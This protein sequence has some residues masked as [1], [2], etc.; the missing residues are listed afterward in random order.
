[1]SPLALPTLLLFAAPPGPS[2]REESFSLARPAE[3]VA[4]LRAGCEACSWEVKG[5][6][7]AVLVLSV[8]GGYSQHLTLVRGAVPQEYRVLLGTLEAGAHRLSV[9]LD[10]GMTPRAVRSVAVDPVT[11]LPVE[12][13]TPEHRALA[14]APLLHAR[15]NTLG[16]FSDLPLLSWYE[17]E[18]TPRGTRL[19][20]SVVFSN[21][22]GGT[23]PDRLLATW[24]RL[25]DI[26]YVYGVELDAAGQVLEETYQGRDHKILAFRGKRLGRH[27]LLWV[28]T[29]NNM[30]S[31]EGRTSLR[32]APAPTPVD[33]AEVSR[34]AVM[35][36]RPWTYMVSSEEARREGRVATDARPGSKRIVDPRRYAYLEAC[37]ETRDATLAFGVATAGANG[38]V[39]WR[40]SDAGQSSFRIARS[41]DHFPNGCFRGAVALPKG[42]TASDVKAVRLKAF[43]RVA[44]KGE[45]PLRP[46]AGEAR[47]LRVNRL[48]LLGEDDQPG[49]SLF[50]WSGDVPLVPEGPPHELHVESPRP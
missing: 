24:G 34:E 11:F 9:T 18:T 32:Y 5:R 2:L 14:H 4:T 44:R 31:D 33:L 17:T 40:D 6:E 49:P 1:M 26:E 10:Q 21:E 3:V 12:P 7:A 35:D 19:R 47:L 30:V 27:P 28:V 39:L 41:A 16:R 48:F 42:A 43:T 15:K 25:T 36:A 37:A 20:Y 23:P 45:A 29:D 50:S 38:E 13:G 22:D 46:G 8:D